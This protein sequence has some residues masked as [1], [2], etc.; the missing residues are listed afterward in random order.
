MQL[1]ECKGG[2]VNLQVGANKG[3]EISFDVANFT[4]DGIHS[5]VVKMQLVVTHLTQQMVI[6]LYLSSSIRRKGCY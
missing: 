4:F 6:V 3:D 1:A 5:Q 2:K